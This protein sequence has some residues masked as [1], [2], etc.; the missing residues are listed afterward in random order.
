MHIVL[1]SDNN[2][3]EFVAVVITSALANNDDNIT[4]HLLSNG[5]SDVTIQQL[6]RHIPADRGALQIYD[7]SNL[8]ERLQIEVPNT[9]AISSYA[10]LF[11]ASILPQNIDKVLYVDC[12]V[13]IADNLDGLW[14]TDLQG[15]YIAGVLDTLPNNESKEKVGL[16]ENEPYF[17]SGVLLINLHQWR[18][19]NLQQQFIDFLF[20]HNGHVH[21]HD[22]GIING[23]CKGKIKILHPQY[24]CTTNYFSH[25][26]SLL[27]KT[28]TPF[29]SQKEVEEAT[30]NP[31]I[32][33]F[34]EG[35]Y[36]RPWIENSLHPLASV[37]QH[38]HD[39]TEWANTPLRKDKRTTLV[40]CLSW[41]FLHLPYPIYSISA[42]MVTLLAKVLKRA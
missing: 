32:I 28:N 16:P 38:Y 23:V 3:V 18:K 13:V 25:P 17:N 1:A 7:I 35:F 41:E 12:D 30:Q 37:Y 11:L 39:M 36:N 8:K 15:D 20:A 21:H 29:Y 6:K 26:Y 27:Q 19:D 40:K 33:H 5:I 31:A 14:Q 9:I 24:N 4:F 22:Q 2:Y 42:R 34:T 10:R